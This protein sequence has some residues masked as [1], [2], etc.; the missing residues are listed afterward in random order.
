MVDKIARFYHSFVTGLIKIYFVDI[1]DDPALLV[2][3]VNQ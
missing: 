1:Y 2:A 3:S